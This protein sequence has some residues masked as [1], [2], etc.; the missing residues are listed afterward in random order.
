MNAENNE[1]SVLFALKVFPTKDKS[2]CHRVNASN[3]FKEHE[4][5][6]KLSINCSSVPG[7]DQCKHRIIFVEINTS[8]LMSTTHPS[9]IIL[10]M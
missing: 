3:L 1:I 5:D 6:I 8:Q 2:C 10:Q 9:L 7:Y 4:T